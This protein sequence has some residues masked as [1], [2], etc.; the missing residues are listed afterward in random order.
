MRPLFPP[1]G[2]RAVLLGATG[3]VL[4]TQGCTPQGTAGAEEERAAVFPDQDGDTIMDHHEGLDLPESGEEGELRWHDDDLDGT[5]N[6][7]DLDSDED[8]I[9]DEVEAGDDDLLTFPIDTDRDGLSD[10][11]DRDADGNCLEDAVEGIV[12]LD[13]DGNGA[14]MD[15][16]NDGDGILD[17]WEIGDAALCEPP[18][19]D[20]DGTPDYLDLDSDGDGIGDRFEGG[21]SPFDPVPSDTDGDGTPDYL[22][23]DSDDDGLSDSEEGGVGGPEEEP[24]DTDGDG[25]YDFQDTDSD[26]DG[27][28]DSDEVLI[29]DTDP[30]DAD[31][32]DDGFNDGAEVATGSDPADPESVIEGIYVEV[33]ERSDVT[34]SFDFELSVSMGDVAFLID[35][36]GSMT[37]TI[38]AMK[39]EYAAIVAELSA[40]IPD[41]EYGVATFDDYHLLPF[42]SGV[43]QPFILSQSVTHDVAA[44]QAALSAIPLHF[45]EDGPESSTEALVQTLTGRG[46]DQDCDG[47][48]DALDDVLPYLS[49]GADPFGGTAGQHHDAATAGGGTRGGMGFRE[50]ALPVVVY[51]TDN[52]MRDGAVG[53]SP[54]GCPADGASTEISAAAADLGA[55]LV[56]ISV[57]MWGPTSQMNA[58]ADS[59]GSL[60]DL[61]G[62]GT[63]D[64]RL[65]FEWSGSSAAFRT[66]VTGAIASLISDLRFDF[67]TLEIEGDDWGFVTD[68]EPPSQAVAGEIDG[69]V[70]SFELTFRG[71]VAST[72]HDQLFRL[73]LNVLGDGT[74][75]LDALDIFVLVPGTA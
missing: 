71:T 66:T 50:H 15:L 23:L 52:V 9:P 49:S 11:V 32:D 1:S 33:P 5:P 58:I 60:A 12:D 70:L 67:V 28:T 2:L 26:G 40:T 39:T 63:A 21:T 46:Y 25:F 35:T 54:G 61:D 37:S 17:T 4:L 42:G 19:S 20:G 14:F 44:V 51:A 72:E 59:T 3:A 64:D 48:F 6:M 31:S 18:D 38:D 36:T 34:E 69:E 27:L 73:T 8:G 22:D 30:Y 53:P 29:H 41:A 43:D 65:V 24:R 62:D 75:L 55:R 13:G 47:A 56:G 16:D 74:T 57:G 45:G 7:L 68:V 10:F